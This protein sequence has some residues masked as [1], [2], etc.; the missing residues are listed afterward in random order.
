MLG[1][2]ISV[3]T[4][5]EEPDQDMLTWKDSPGDTVVEAGV[6][7]ILSE[8]DILWQELHVVVCP[9]LADTRDALAVS[10]MPTATT[11]NTISII[12]FPIL[13]NPPC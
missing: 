3:R 13:L 5:L 4:P 9:E 11:V 2:F 1:Q 7:L 10:A 6:A 8:L 12:H